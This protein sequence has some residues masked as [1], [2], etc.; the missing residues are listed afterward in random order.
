MKQKGFTLV[1]LIV[2]IVILGILA[3]TALP[4]F[5]DFSDDAADAAVKGVAGGISA[6]AALNYAGQSAGKAVTPATLN[7]TA[8]VVCT[9]ANLGA[10]LTTGWPTGYTVA[11]AAGAAACAAGGN[12]TCTITEPSSKAKT[13]DAVVTCY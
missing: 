12:T 4:K 9:S 13:A 11:A 3:A 2:V 10:L 1:E 7:G 6:A 8:A 5:I